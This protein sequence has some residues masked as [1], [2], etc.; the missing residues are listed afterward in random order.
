MGVPKRSE[1]AMRM[2]ALDILSPREETGGAQSHAPD[3]FYCEARRCAFPLGLA[4]MLAK[5]V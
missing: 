4:V 5:R 2:D 1:T 3:S